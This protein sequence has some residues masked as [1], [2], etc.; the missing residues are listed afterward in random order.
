MHNNKKENF[1]FL[2]P[3]FNLSLIVDFGIY[4]KKVSKFLKFE[5]VLTQNFILQNFRDCFDKI[6][7]IMLQI[8]FSLINPS[9]RFFQSADMFP[10]IDPVDLKVLKTLTLS[11]KLIFII[12][13]S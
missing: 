4:L 11:H 3:H 6:F 5:Y 10:R 13:M 2:S 9:I 8:D 7:H 1:G 12:F